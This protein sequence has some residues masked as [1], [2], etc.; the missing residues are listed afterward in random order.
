M[1]LRARSLS[2]RAITYRAS[3]HLLRD[4]SLPLKRLG[5]TG[6]LECFVGRVPGFYFPID[7]EVFSIDGTMPDLVIDATL[8]M[9]TAAAFS[10]ELAY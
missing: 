7:G 10:Q 3:P 1:G 9:K 4:H 2:N 8:P 5:Q 6:L